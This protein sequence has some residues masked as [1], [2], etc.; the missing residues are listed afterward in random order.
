T[1]H[2]VRP[3]RASPAVIGSVWTW[4][5]N[6][7][8]ELGRRT[9]PRIDPVPSAGPVNLPG[10]LAVALGGGFTLALAP[11]RTVWAWGANH[12]GQLGADTGL[13]PGTLPGTV[14]SNSDA[15]VRVR[16]LSGVS[17]IAGGNNFGLALLSDGTVW[18][19]G[20]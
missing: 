20:D 2:D 12:R 10:A 17:A 19:W 14:T 15:P 7:S 6:T 16:G 5:A 11:D 18:A 4:G 1:I 8:G 3:A 13:A 9:G